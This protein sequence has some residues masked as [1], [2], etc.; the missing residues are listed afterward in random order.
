MY[1]SEGIT[2][3]IYIELQFTKFKPLYLLIS[4]ERLNFTSYPSIYVF[5]CRKLHLRFQRP[6]PTCPCS[7][8]GRETAI[9]A[10]D[11]FRRSWV[12][13][14]PRSESFSLSPCRPISFLSAIAQEIW[15]GIFTQQSNL[16]SFNHYTVL[17]VCKY[18]YEWD[19]FSVSIEL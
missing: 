6:A 8:I 10:S 11:L 3:D 9:F 7:S 18:V 15:F 2:L 1:R 4:T 17:P 19:Q 14:P 5:I 12:Q 13:I 16:P